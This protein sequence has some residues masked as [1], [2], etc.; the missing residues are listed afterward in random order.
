[1]EQPWKFVLCV[2]DH[3]ID[4]VFFFLSL[5][6]CDFYLF[7]CCVLSSFFLYGLVEFIDVCI[8]W[9]PDPRRSTAQYQGPRISFVGS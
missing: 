3:F 5:L 1:M 8:E 4:F 9:G 2:V 7:I 6:Y